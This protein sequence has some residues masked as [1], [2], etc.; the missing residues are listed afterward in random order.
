[1]LAS[2]IDAL[3]DKGESLPADGETKTLTTEM[4][5]KSITDTTFTL[6]TLSRS[7]DQYT[8]AVKM[9]YNGKRGDDS[10]AQDYEIALALTH[11]PDSTGTYSGNMSYQIQDK[12]QGGTCASSSTST[13]FKIARKGSLTYQKKADKQFVLDAREAQYCTETLDSTAH[14]TTNQLSATNAYSSSVPSGWS[15]NFNW[16]KAEFAQTDLAGQYAYAWQAGPNDSH[17]RIL[18]VGLNPSKVSDETGAIN[19]DGE[20]WYG[21]GATLTSSATTVGQINGF[22][23]NW[24]GPGSSNTLVEKA[25]RQF[26]SKGTSGLYETVTGGSNLTYAP[27]NSCLYSGGI[28]QYDR[29]LSGV[30]DTADTVKVVAGSPGSGELQYQLFPY[31]GLYFTDTTTYPDIESIISARGFS[32]PSDPVAP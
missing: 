12:Y 29:D 9:V 25:Q 21:Y 10:T 17:S 7:G 31:T 19:A 13:C 23:C 5:A 16:F 30:L 27:T 4:N 2:L 6:A 22:I 24:A 1:V 32:L 20:A 15:D 26:I 8:Y 3:Y 11:A 28:F 14:T 18:N